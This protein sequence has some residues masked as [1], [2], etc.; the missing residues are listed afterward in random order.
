MEI[1]S[2]AVIC[3]ITLVVL[4]IQII[5]TLR[6]L[7]YFHHRSHEKDEEYGLRTLTNRSRAAS[8]QENVRPA[9]RNDT[10][11]LTVPGPAY[12]ASSRYSVKTGPSDASSRYEA[13]AP[14]SWHG[15]ADTNQRKKTQ[16]SRR[17]TEP[18]S[19]NP[20]MNDAVSKARKKDI[21]AEVWSKKP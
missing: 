8:V 12:P 1:E 5:V 2:I 3:L 9:S 10:E 7:L 16:A 21:L 15:A 19:G 20:F 13:N 11:E 17:E 18:E 4:I 14:S 6:L